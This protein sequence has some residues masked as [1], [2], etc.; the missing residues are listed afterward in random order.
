MCAVSHFAP[1]GRYPV[2][3]SD[4]LVSEK[5]ES[6]VV[7]PEAV[8]ITPTLFPRPPTPPFGPLMPYQAGLSSIKLRAP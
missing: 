6:D 5:P 3:F 2:K 8:T 7:H 1:I 4:D